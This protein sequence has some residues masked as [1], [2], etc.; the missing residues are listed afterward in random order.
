MASKKELK[1]TVNPVVAQ[2]DPQPNDQRHFVILSGFIGEVTPDLVKVYPGLDLRTFYTIPREGIAFVE[3]AGGG[4]ASD[5]TRLVVDSSTKV[6][7]TNVHER[8]IEAQ[9]LAGAIATSTLGTLKPCPPPVHPVPTT[10]GHVVVV[11]CAAPPAP[12]PPPPSQCGGDPC[13]SLESH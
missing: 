7:V 10:T 13:A 11:P 4:L 5:P 6:E 3:Q 2:I 1:I 8:S 12:P 9:F